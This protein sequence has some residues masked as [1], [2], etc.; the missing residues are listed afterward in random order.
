MNKARAS[1]IYTLL[2]GLDFQ[3]KVA[4]IIRRLDDLVT[5]GVQKV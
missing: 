2:E 3:A 4:T 1:G 5:K